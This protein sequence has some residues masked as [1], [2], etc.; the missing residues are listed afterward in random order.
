MTDDCADHQTRTVLHQR[1][2]V[3][4][5]DRRSSAALVRSGVRVRTRFMRVVA[6]SPALPVRVG[7]AANAGRWIIRAALGPEALM[8]V[9]AWIAT[10]NG[11]RAS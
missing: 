7:V 9:Q 10:R 4:A 1:V 3:V 11:S 5:Q 2:S 8:L 6:G